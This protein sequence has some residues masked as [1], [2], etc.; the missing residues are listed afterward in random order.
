MDYTNKRRYKIMKIKTVKITATNLATVGGT[1]VTEI[2]AGQVS[3]KPEELRQTPASKIVSLNIPIV[4][5]NI[6]GTVFGPEERLPIWRRAETPSDSMNIRLMYWPI[7]VSSRS[8]ILVPPET[9]GGLI[10]ILAACISRTHNSSFLGSSSPVLR[11]S[12]LRS[13]LQHAE[14]KHIQVPYAEHKHTQV[15]CPRERERRAKGLYPE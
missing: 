9:A 15:P 14:H 4:S 5:L 3:A 6:P 11:P 8:I 2:G 12:G 1:V 7:I 10:V 13:C